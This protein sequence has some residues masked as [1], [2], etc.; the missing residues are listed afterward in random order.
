[1]EAEASRTKAVRFPAWLIVL[2]HWQM[3]EYGS[4]LTLPVL[5][6]IERYVS[7]MRGAS[8]RNDLRAVLDAA[9]SCPLEH[10][11]HFL[12]YNCPNV[13][14]LVLTEVPHFRPPRS[15]NSIPN[16]ERP[17][18]CRLAAELDTSLPTEGEAF[19][20]LLDLLC[21]QFSDVIDR[22]HYSRHGLTFGPMSPADTERIERALEVGLLPRPAELSRWPF[23]TL[24]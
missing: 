4:A 1:M 24:M 21:A 14:T 3:V 16:P 9:R 13:Q 15:A 2:R 20:H 7:D 19:E 18:Q 22:G 5:V 23:K 17:E 8:A 11:G 6:G 12:I 10:A